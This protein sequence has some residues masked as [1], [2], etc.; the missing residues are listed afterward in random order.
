MLLY[1]HRKLPKEK[2]LDF[3]YAIFTAK[4]THAATCRNFSLAKLKHEM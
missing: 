2:S 1:R 4:Q 3:A